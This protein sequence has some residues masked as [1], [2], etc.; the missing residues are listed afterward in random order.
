MSSNI[1]G[2]RFGRSVQLVPKTLEVWR[3]KVKRKHGY[4]WS[5]AYPINSSYKYVKKVKL[6][7]N[8]NPNI[9]S[10]IIE[11]H[12]HISTTILQSW[13]KWKF[14]VVSLW[15]PCFGVRIPKW[16]NLG[17]R[18]PWWTNLGVCNAM[19]T[20]RRRCHLVG[21]NVC[22]FCNQLW[23]GFTIEKI[24]RHVS[25][26]RKYDIKFQNHRFCDVEPPTHS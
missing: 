6:N 10:E 9:S 23:D 2:S 8:S 20:L 1:C 19:H 14:S 11:C 26:F 4:M 16:P 5:L 25:K 22:D 3:E 21:I 12:C 15:I 24:W 7:P 18:I 17:V 13:G